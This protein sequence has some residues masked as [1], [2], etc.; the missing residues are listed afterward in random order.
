MGAGVGQVMRGVVVPDP[1]PDPDPGPVPEPAALIVICAEE[2][3][4]CGVALLPEAETLFALTAIT[5]AAATLTV[6]AALLV[7]TPLASVARAGL[8]TVQSVLLVTSCVVPSVKCAV[9]FRLTVPPTV[10]ADGVAV[11]EREARLWDAEFVAQP[12]VRIRALHRSPEHTRDK[13]GIRMCIAS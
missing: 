3:R 6:P 2:F 5:Y 1:D 11:M 8:E 7:K 4:V 12:V 9:A 13:G 10:T